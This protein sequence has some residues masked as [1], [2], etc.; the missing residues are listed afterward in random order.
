MD[1][2]DPYA[3]IMRDECKWL[4]ECQAAEMVKKKNNQSLK[5]PLQVDTKT[6]ASI[7]Y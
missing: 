3:V 2:R 6:N 1:S 4:N 5:E 7:H